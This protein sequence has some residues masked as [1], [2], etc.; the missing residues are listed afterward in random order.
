MKRNFDSFRGSSNELRAL[1][2]GNWDETP[3]SDLCGQLV[4][5]QYAAYLVKTH[6]KANGSNL[7]HGTIKEY[8]RKLLQL[9][10]EKFG[11]TPAH[12]AFF[13]CTVPNSPEVWFRGLLGQVERECYAIAVA[14]GEPMETQ[15]PAISRHELIPVCRALTIEGSGDSLLRRALVVCAWAGFGRTSEAGSISID[16]MQYDSDTQVI[17]AVLPQSKVSRDKTIVF[18]PGVERHSDVFKAIGDLMNSGYFKRKPYDPEGASFFFHTFGDVKDGTVNAKIGD[19]L[20]AFTISQANTDKTFEQ[21]RFPSMPLG[22][23]GQSLRVGAINSCNT[24]MP[25]EFVA[26]GSGHVLDKDSALG[27]YYRNTIAGAMPSEYNYNTCSLSLHCHNTPSTFH[28]TLTRTRIA[29]CTT[30]HRTCFSL[31]CYR[32][33]QARPSWPAITRYRGVVQDPARCLPRSS[34]W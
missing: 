32:V 22:V 34:R 33:L 9:A 30:T 4:Y 11:S 5:K 20:K 12:T 19:T 23:T 3:A 24:H 21:Y 18:V 15:A 17:K 28:N 25:V 27:V 13:S 26:A 31:R 16:N 29:H 1:Y 6:Q 2:P 7:A 14:A 8:L 10:K